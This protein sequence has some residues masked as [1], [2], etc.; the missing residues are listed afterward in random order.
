MSLLSVVATF[1]AAGALAVS[2]KWL[3]VRQ[4]FELAGLAAM[5]PVNTFIGW[6]IV[7]SVSESGFERAVSRG[8]LGGVCVVMLFVVTLFL[9]RAGYS[10]RT[11]VSLG[12]ASWLLAFVVSAFVSIKR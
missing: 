9:L 6:Y 4:N 5:F 8:L 11:S 10:I 1:C 3:S 12:V 2:I 7:K